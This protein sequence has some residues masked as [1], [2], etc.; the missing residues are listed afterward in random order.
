L[1]LGGG[2]PELFAEQLAANRP[3]LEEVRSAIDSGMPCYAECGG[4]IFLSE[5][6]RLLNGSVLQMAGVVPGIMEMRPNLQ[7]FGY[8]SAQDARLGTAHGHEFH[9]ARWSAEPEAANAWNVT[10][11][12]TS[13]SRSEGFRIHRLHASFVHLYF[14]ANESMMEALFH[15]H[16]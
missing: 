15:V 9:H 6:I 10:R 8:C 11:R 16:R 1:I 14:P 4:M 5:G 3:L 13:V 2:F 12:R 7:H